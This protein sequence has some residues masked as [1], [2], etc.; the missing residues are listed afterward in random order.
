MLENKFKVGDTVRIKQEKI[1]NDRPCTV[2]NTLEGDMVIVKVAEPPFNHEDTKR[3]EPAYEIER[4][5]GNC[6]VSVRDYEAHQYEREIFYEDDLEL[7][8]RRRF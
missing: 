8:E 4:A 6:F 2:T 1:D 3:M 7:V 5:D